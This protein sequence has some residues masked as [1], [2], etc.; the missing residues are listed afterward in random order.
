MDETA[1]IYTTATLIGVVQS[2]LMPSSFLLDNFFPNIVEH[3][4]EEVAVDVEIG[5]RRMT[6]YV[7]P[8]V[9]GR[10]TESRR[11]QTNTFK[12][13]YAKDWRPL[14]PNRP[15][16]RSIGEQIGGQLTPLEREQ[17]NI[18][19][20]LEDQID[21]LT[22]RNEWGAAQALQNGSVVVS[23]EGFQTV[24][25]D[26]G[27]DSRLTVA[28][29][30]TSVWGDASHIDVNGMDIK[31]VTDINTWQT[32]M[33]KVSGAV[34]TD[35]V[36]TTKSWNLFLQARDLNGAKIVP[37]QNSSGNIINP[38]SAPVQGAVHQGTWGSK[39]LWLYNDWFVDPDTDVEYPMLTDGMLLLLSRQIQGTRGFGI[40]RDP[41]IG[42]PSMAFAPKSWTT[43]NP[44]R[45][46]LMVQ[47]A[48]LMIPF[49]PN[50]SMA[51]LV[52]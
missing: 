6:P 17:A 12:P 44:G 50:A 27:R 52:A 33:L 47:S 11:M 22:R 36:F 28:L 51:V 14:D 21:M 35:L 5:K 39:N 3:D 15:V 9:P 24:T 7:S 16:R 38:A 20:E 32:T 40:I 42:Y 19:F 4:T 46:F 25:I 48:P 2:L 49:R 43:Q 34:V 18:A 1:L 30:S 37:K 45:R 41:E 26:F 29:S 31:P 10:I 8:L 23:G 13:P